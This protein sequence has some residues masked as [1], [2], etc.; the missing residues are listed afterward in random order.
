MP[1]SSVDL[2]SQ[3]LPGFRGHGP[4]LRYIPGQAQG[5]PLLNNLAADDFLFAFKT[6]WEFGQIVIWFSTVKS[7]AINKVRTRCFKTCFIIR[8]EVAGFSFAFC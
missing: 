7:N 5:Q 6:D 3:W 8:R 2:P 1:A 4:L